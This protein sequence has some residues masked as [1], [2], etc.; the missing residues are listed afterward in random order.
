MRSPR[1]RNVVAIAAA[2]L[3]SCPG[4]LAAGSEGAACAVTVDVVTTA[5]APAPDGYGAE[6]R[7]GGDRRFAPLANGSVRFDDVPCGSWTVAAGPVRGVVG[8]LRVL[9]EARADVAV[10]G[11]RTV[12]RLEV[13]PPDRRIDVR[14][15]DGA[16][17]AVSL[18]GV[19]AWGVSDSD[20]RYPGG[21]YVS[22][23]RTGVARMFL[24]AGR[25]RLEARTGFDV[26]EVRVDGAVVPDPPVVDVGD[27]D[28]TVTF[29]FDAGTAIAGRV[30][31]DRGDP[32]GGVVLDLVEPSAERVSYLAAAQSGADGRFRVSGRLP[33][34]VR[35]RGEIGIATYEPRS[36]VVDRVERASDLVFVRVPDEGRSRLRGVVVRD[37]DDRPVAGA[38]VEIHPVGR[39][40]PLE[41]LDGSTRAT[42]A[43]DGSFDVACPPG[44]E[45]SIAVDPPDEATLRRATLAVPDADCSEVVEIRLPAALAVAGRVRDERGEPAAGIVVRADD[46]GPSATTDVDGS[47]RIGGLGDREVRLSVPPARNGAPRILTRDGVESG[48]DAFPVVVQP[49]FDPTPVR[50]RLRTPGRV[51]VRAVE[52]DG[53]PAVLGEVVAFRPG[54]EEPIEDVR[55]LRPEL[56]DRPDLLC[57]P[58]LPPGAVQIR[59]GDDDPARVVPVWWPGEIDRDLGGLVTVESG[60]TVDL[61]PVVVRPAG[62]LWLRAVG[63]ALDRDDPP[64]VR[65][66]PPAEGEESE[67]GSVESLLPAWIEIVA[68]RD[69]DRAAAGEDDVSRVALRVVPAGRWTVEVCPGK[70]GCAGAKTIWRTAEP[71]EVAGGQ[72]YRVVDVVRTGT[73]PPASAPR[74]P[75]RPAED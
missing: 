26:V 68:A 44:E 12:V 71:V 5:G 62:R 60:E 69:E 25:Y 16:G 4:L 74:T 64:E 31:D 70:D 58:D 38:R 63:L 56:R 15:V 53:E 18:G 10:S 17:E 73:R 50:L 57:I 2:L 75:P 13:P 33:V 47:F 23:D 39:G 41:A 20:G 9:D 40:L 66:V 19:V 3:C 21:A 11:E 46:G 51:C 48:A 29:R 22:V 24:P 36:I 28:A 72:G 35:P 1:S 45:R 7:N 54:E 14:F 32:V 8:W 59:I 37:D 61:G 55:A 27:R 34:V 6:I 42:T 67:D 65:L 49:S 30:V 52:P 43:G